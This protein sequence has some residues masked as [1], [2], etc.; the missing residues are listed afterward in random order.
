M[1]NALMYADDLIIMSPTQEGLQKSL[2]ALNDY[3]KKWKLNINNKKTKCMTF[4]KGTN[5]KNTNF[6]INYKRIENTKEFKY[7][8]ITIKSK[9]CTFTP[10]LTDLSSKANKA[11][12]TILSKLPIKLAPIK[13]MLKLFDTCITP[14]LLYGSEVWAPFMNH[15][16]IKW[17]AT[18]TE[19]IHTQFLKRLLGVNRSTTNVLVRGEL[20]RHSLQENILRRNINYIKYVENKDPQSLAKQAANYEILHAEKRDSFYSLLKKYEQ[21]LINNNIKLVS[22]S[23]LRT[24][25]RE[26]FNTSWKTQIASFPKADIYRQFKDRVKFENYLVDIKNRKHRVTFTKFR[27][28]DHCLMI[29]RGRHKRPII[30]REQRFC[31]VCPTKVENEAHF[32]IQCNAYKNR[33]ELFITVETE[34]P[35]FVNL[36]VQAQFIFLMSQEN[37]LLNYKIV[38]TIHEWLSVRLQ[39]A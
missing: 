23:K 1:F 14:I 19:K 24:L 2:D 39:S 10:T 20:G 8:G 9:N 37:K 30:P 3:C 29:E 32:L 13:T 28:S 36:N 31:P 33:N 6:T 12:Y 11:I 21:K 16:W 4:S 35:H 25:I 34:V 5:N 22:K 17:D 38:S 7:L 15:D 26:E 27:L 18:H